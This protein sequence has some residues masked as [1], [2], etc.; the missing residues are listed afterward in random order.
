MRFLWPTLSALVF[1]ASSARAEEPITVEDAP[2]TH[3][4]EMD[5]ERCFAEVQRRA[6]PV[7]SAGEVRGVPIPVRLTGRMHG[8]DVHSSLPASQR[9]SSPYEVFDCRLALALDD[10]TKLLAEHD[11]VELIHMSAYRPPP[12]RWPTDKPGKRHG[13]GLALDAAVF[14]KSDGQKLIVEKHFRGRR[15]A[16]PCPTKH[17]KRSAETQAIRDIYCGARARG[18]FHVMLSPNF[19]WAHRNH[20]HLEVSAHPRGFYVH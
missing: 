11:V 14:V 16:N 10:F 17:A 6:L 2:A 8:V 15:W 3:Y 13:A 20:F 4:G 19:N 7:V 1:C 12:K 9:A 5:A 18:L